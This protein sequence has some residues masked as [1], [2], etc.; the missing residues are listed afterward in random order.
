MLTFVVIG[1]G[2]TGVELAGAIAELA[3]KALVADF[4]KIQP[5]HAR[6]LLIE[7]GPRLLPAFPER[8]SA[9]AKRALERLGVEVRLGEAVT[10]CDDQGVM[11]GDERIQAGVVLWA[12]GVAA[13]PAAKWLGAESDRAG[14]VKVGPDLSL[15]GH[16][17][18][19]VIGDTA[20]AT[21]PKG[22]PLPGI[23]PAA[24][25]AG[26]VCR[27]GD[28]RAPARPPDAA[29]PLPASGQSRHHRP[30]CRGRRFRLAPPVGMGRVA[31]LGVVH[32]YFLIGFRNRLVVALDWLWAYLTFQRGA[33][34]ITGHSDG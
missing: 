27:G 13:S 10:A 33:R 4:R 5:H 25:Q 11:V 31:A 3:R 24:K 7:A 9:A 14:R 6:V 17:E 28:P 26:R 2:P 22:N 8:L 34:L 32:I 12:A 1:G 23:A 20:L 21:D 18:I 30:H 19:F 29:V 16:P 15:P